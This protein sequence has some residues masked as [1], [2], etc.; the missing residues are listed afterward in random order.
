MFI[1][2]LG[3]DGPTPLS[4]EDMDNNE[5]LPIINLSKIFYPLPRALAFFM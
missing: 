4:Y 2:A 1:R 3:G 5:G